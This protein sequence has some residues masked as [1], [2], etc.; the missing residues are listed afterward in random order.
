MRTPGFVT[1]ALALAHTAALASLPPESIEE[2]VT[3]TNA[4]PAE[5]LSAAGR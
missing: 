3:T 4:Y 1:L 2:F 5:E